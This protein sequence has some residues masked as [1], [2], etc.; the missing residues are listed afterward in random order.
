MVASQKTWGRGESGTHSWEHRMAQLAPP[1]CSV[2]SCPPLGAE[3]E[4]QRNQLSDHRARPALLLPHCLSLPTGNAGD[5]VWSTLS[6]VTGRAG[7][8]DCLPPA[9]TPSSPGPRGS[10]LLGPARPSH[11][12]SVHPFR[13]CR[14]GSWSLSSPWPSSCRTGGPQA[15][16]GVKGGTGP[17]SLR[18]AAGCRAQGCVRGGGAGEGGAAGPLPSELLSLTLPR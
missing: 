4:G 6:Q 18:E 2:E 15:P 14:V 13:E 9:A 3:L 10:P 16:P 5:F 7:L 12:L 1:L 11:S 8:C 17:Y